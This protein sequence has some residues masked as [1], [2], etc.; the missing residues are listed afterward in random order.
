MSWK[1]LYV[2]IA[3]EESQAECREFRA[4]GHIAYSSDIQPCRPGGNPEWHIQ[5]D[6][7]P[8]L[9]SRTTFL[10]QDG[11]VQHVPRWDLIICHPP[12]TYLTKVGSV[13]LFNNPDFVLVE[14]GIK[15]FVNRERYLR[16]M[17]AR[18]FFFECL[19]ANAPYVAVENPIPMSR[20][21]LPR[22]TTFACPSWFGCK[23]S[24]KTLYW[25]K[26]LPDIMPDVTPGNVRCL[27]RCS[28]GKYRSRTYP[29][30][31][32]AIAEQWSNYILDDLW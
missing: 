5:G 14:N 3:C 8:L 29:G 6:C 22:P 23:Y 11:S 1:Q 13:W 16:M 17:F 24:K 20:A 32:K 4:L 21:Q 10:T 31:A 19:G 28:R 2:L 7:R 27:V 15:L 25:L 12:C 30:L 18:D 26:N 9:Q